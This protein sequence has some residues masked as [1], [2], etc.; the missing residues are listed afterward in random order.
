MTFVDILVESRSC[1]PILKVEVGGATPYF[2][3]LVLYII[4]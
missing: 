1:E 4:F 2:R 3:A